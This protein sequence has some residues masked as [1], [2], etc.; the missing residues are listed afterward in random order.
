MSNPWTCV[1]ERLLLS[2]PT[3]PWERHFQDSNPDNPRKEV[4]INEAPASFRHGSH[5]FVAYSASACWT[6]DYAMDLLNV[7]L[8]SDLM[9]ADSWEKA[10][11]PVF[12]NRFVTV[13]MDR[14][15]GA[16][17]RSPMG[18]TGCCITPTP[19]STKAAKT[20]VPRACNA[21]VGTETA[22]PISAFQRQRK[23]R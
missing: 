18:K 22:C 4:Y 11:N 1:G 3:L 5:L 19:G 20:N 15:M 6:D 12:K 23:P 14:D 10:P 7:R 17:F 13:C 8:D 21:S 16:F 2:A 9:Q